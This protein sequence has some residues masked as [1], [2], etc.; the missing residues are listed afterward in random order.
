M[1]AMGFRYR[2]DPQ[3]QQYAHVSGVALLTPD[4]RLARWLGGVGLEASDLRL[5]LAEA[6]RGGIG[7]LADR[8]LLLCYHYDP[9]TGRYTSVIDRILKIG[10]IVTVLSIAGPI[11]IALHRERQRQQRREPAA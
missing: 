5:A 7:G 1:R 2:W 6:G 9:R 10:A 8:F 4:G 11:A 3:L